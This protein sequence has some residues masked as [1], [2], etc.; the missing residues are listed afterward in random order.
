MI[1]K[2]AAKIKPILIFNTVV[3]NS[4]LA[5]LYRSGKEKNQLENKKKWSRSICVCSCLIV[6]INSFLIKSLFT[7]SNCKRYDKS[8]V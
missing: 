1:A 3:E 7:S 4:F 8:D 2:I 6:S 5:Q